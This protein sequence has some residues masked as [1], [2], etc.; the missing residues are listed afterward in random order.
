MA[1]AKKAKAPIA[2][3]SPAEDVPAIGEDGALHCAQRGCVVPKARAH[4]ALC[5]VC[6]NPLRLIGAKDD[7]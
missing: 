1:R 7:A 5:P 3:R 2:D 6:N 4:D